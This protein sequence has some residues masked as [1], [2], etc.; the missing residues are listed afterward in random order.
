LTGGI[1]AGFVAQ[2]FT[3]PQRSAI[4]ADLESSPRTSALPENTSAEPVREGAARNPSAE[5]PFPESGLD[6]WRT[7]RQAS[8]YTPDNL[9]AKIDGRADLYLQFH[10]VALTF[11][12]Y[13]Q[14]SDEQRTIDVYWYNMGQPDNALGVYRA[15]AP[16][17]TAPLEIGRRAYQAGTAVFFVK[18]A[19]Y[20]QVLPSGPE[21]I[22]GQAALTIARRIAERITESDSDDWASRLLPDRDR[23]QGSFEFLAADVFGLDFLSDVFAADYEIGGKR[24]KLFV[25]R[26]AD[27]AEAQRLLEKYREFFDG[28]GEV[29]WESPDASRRIIA[30]Q[31]GDVIDVVFAKGRYL[32]GA[33]GAEDLEPAR[34]AA[35][36]F[37]ET[38]TPP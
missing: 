9:Y 22:D 28:F 17:D 1:V 4:A 13:V 16:E 36:N 30:G 33:A 11:G 38:L 37:Y 14:A 35:I 34:K 23:V 19:A 25:H 29:L 5:N 6:A 3:Q 27:Q 32:G 18:G 8:R 21:E 20:V 12:A 7:P 2:F 31:A 15:E 10:V 24:I 26:A